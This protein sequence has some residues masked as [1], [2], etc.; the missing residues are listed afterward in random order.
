[1]C[2]AWR[3]L[4][5]AQDM[6]FQWAIP[7]STRAPVERVRVDRLIRTTQIRRPSRM[8]RC[9]VRPTSVPMD[10]HRFFPRRVGKA[11]IRALPQILRSCRTQV[12]MLHPQGRNN[13]AP[14][15]HGAIMVTPLG[16]RV[17]A[18]QFRQAT[19]R[20]ANLNLAGQRV[21][22]RRI[23]VGTDNELRRNVVELGV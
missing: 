13:S 5:A 12:K 9:K 7:T 23:T 10:A 20:L 11:T 21:L 4:V 19:T 15:R 2:T 22:K 1:M 3:H 14:P 17:M 18:T 16:L 8:A 6:E